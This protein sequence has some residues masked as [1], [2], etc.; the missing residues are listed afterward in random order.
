MP[1]WAISA[2]WGS[3]FRF[4]ACWVMRSPSQLRR[5][6]CFPI[7]FPGKAWQ[8]TRRRLCTKQRSH[9][10][11]RALTP[12]NTELGRLRSKMEHLCS[13]NQI[14]YRICGA[15]L[16]GSIHWSEFTC[17]SEW[18]CTGARAARLPL[19]LRG[20]GRPLRRMLRRAPGPA[21]DLSSWKS[22]EH[23]PDT[24]ALD[25]PILAQSRRDAH[26]NTRSGAAAS[27][28]AMAPIR[29]DRRD[30]SRWT[31]AKDLRGRRAKVGHLAMGCNTVLVLARRSPGPAP[32]PRCG[33]AR[34][35][36]QN[37]LF[38]PDATHF[39]QDLLRKRAS[40]ASDPDSFFSLSH[41]KLYEF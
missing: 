10:H 15:A 35:M 28:P 34:R 21:L 29:R 39:Q 8:H 17:M 36:D 3:G 40:R 7:F 18:P 13:G 38:C 26:L 6:C 20:P 32:R 5:G 23:S 11:P 4:G 33:A 31:I 27:K 12:Q 22:W 16:W 30:R 37:H 1:A 2:V 41:Q 24:S 14:A 19:P 9:H 25:S